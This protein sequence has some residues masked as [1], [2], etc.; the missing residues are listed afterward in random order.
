MKRIISVI[1][2]L[3]LMLSLTSVFA[4]GELSAVCV[5]AV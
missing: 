2:S 5:C 4:E 3:V 1:L